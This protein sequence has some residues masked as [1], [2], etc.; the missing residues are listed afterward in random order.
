MS[1]TADRVAETLILAPEFDAQAYVR[2]TA[3]L[4][5]MGAQWSGVGGSQDYFFA[6]YQLGED[7]VVVVENE[8]YLGLSI[9]TDTDTIA[10]ITRI[11]GSCG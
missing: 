10:M 1:G 6:E 8:T 9:T 11:W 2:L 7:S 4:Q 3:L 5:D